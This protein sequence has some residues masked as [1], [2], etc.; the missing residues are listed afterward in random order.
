MS[1]TTVSGSKTSLPDED[2]LNAWPVDIDLEE[3]QSKR[4]RLKGSQEADGI[5]SN[6]AVNVEYRQC[7]KAF[8]EVHRLGLDQ[9]FSSEPESGS[10]QL[11]SD[12]AGQTTQE[13]A[14]A[15]EQVCFGMVSCVLHVRLDNC[16]F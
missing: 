12:T 3:R 11:L 14:S 5:Y 4:C 8:G 16:V 1:S 15:A 10:T 13:G 7:N 2:V 9:E 6:G